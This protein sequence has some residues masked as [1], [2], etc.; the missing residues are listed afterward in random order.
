MVTDST[1]TEL[2]QALDMIRGTKGPRLEALDSLEATHVERV[3]RI[4][5]DRNIVG[6]GIAEKVTEHKATGHLA[7]TFYVEKKVPKSKIKAGK[8]IPPVV[9]VADRTAVFT[10]VQKIGKVQTQVNRRRHPIQSGYSVG[11]RTETGTLA[12][13]VKKGRKRLLLSNSHVLAD[14]GRGKHGDR[15]F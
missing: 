5:E 12:A 6:I 7:L 8:L 13:I 14:S 1:P 15:I 10:D 9:S 2:L 3:R 4:F 11:N